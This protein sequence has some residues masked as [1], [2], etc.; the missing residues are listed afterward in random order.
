[1]SVDLSTQ[2][3]GLSLYNPLVASA[4]PLTASVDGLRRLED[5]GVAAAV[6][7]SLFEE[8]FVHD[9]AE[10]NRLYE[11]HTQSFAE[12][13][14]YFPELDDYH[15]GPTDYLKH[16]QGAKQ[17]VSIPV[18]GSLNG[19]SEGGWTRYAREI[20]SAGADALE[21]NIYFVPTDPEMTGADVENRYVDLVGTVRDSVSIPLAVKIGSQFSSIPNIAQRLVEAGA[22]GLV[23]FNRYLE[24]DIDLESLQITPDLVLSSR[25]E[26]RLPL[27]WIAI[28]RDDIQ[29]SLAATSGA[30]LAEDVVKLLL[31]GADVVMMTS[32]LL[33][34]GPEYVKS[35]RADLV[36][37]LEEHEYASV[38][39]MKGSM[40]LANCPE[41]SALARSNYMK[42]LI[43]YS[44]DLQ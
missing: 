43:S 12:S 21:L 18:I 20:E 30:H 8:Q 4:G 19:Y 1:M 13:L 37:W 38:K 24:P 32:V 40:S 29:A 35:L 7:P 33:T 16:V 42:A 22:N 23:L 9:E 6:L 39:Q 14:D 2:Y 10:I 11:H 44:S 26:L 34:H 27:R 5:A 25:H 41:P 28:M 3:L 15:A 31:V 17:A 36:N